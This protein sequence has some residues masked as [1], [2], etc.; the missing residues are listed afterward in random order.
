MDRRNVGAVLL[1]L[2]LLAV[3]AVGGVAATQA[4]GVGTVDAQ[5]DSAVADAD[6]DTA[7]VQPGLREASGETEV[8]VSLPASDSASSPAALRAHASVT[9]EPLM[10]FAADRPGVTV[11]QTFWLANAALVT[12]DTARVS[13]SD[14]AAVAG[15]RALHENAEFETTAGATAGAALP[16]PA[17]G[18]ANNSYTYGLEQINAPTAWES[19]N[20]TGENASV[21][22]LDT[23]VAASHPDLEVAGWQEFDG[24]GNPVDSEPN[25]GDGHGT[26]V[27]GTVSGPMNPA[28]D[29]PAYG[30]APDVDLYGVKVLTDD[31]GGSFAQIIAGME[32]AVNE[33]VDVISMSLGATGFYEQM[34]EPVQNAHAAGTIVVAS[35]GNSGQGSTG[36]P[37]NVYESVAVGASNSNQGIADF[38]SGEVVDTAADWGDSAPADWPD[39]YTV[40]TVAA[41]GVSTLSSVPGGG[42][43]GTYSGTSMAAPHVSGV[44]ALAESAIDR[45]LS[46]QEIEAALEAT[47]FKPADAPA[48]PGE[49]DD[50]YGSGIVDASAFIAFLQDTDGPLLTLTASA[51]TTVETNESLTVNYTV[52]NLGGAAGTESEINLVVNGTVADTETNTTV[53]PNETVTGSLTFDGVDG[54]EEGD[55]IEWTVEMVDTNTTSSGSTSVGL[56]PGTEIAIQSIEYPDV[57]GPNGELSVNYTLENLGAESGTESFVDLIVNG[58]DSGF[59]DTDFD[60]TVPGGGTASGTLTFSSVSDYFGPDET[61]EFTVE[62]WDFGDVAAGNTTVEV[63]DEPVLGLVSADA[64]TT[65]T[66]GDDL[67]INYTIENIGSVAGTESSVELLVNGTPE[68]VDT[69]VSVPGQ[70][71]ANGTLVFENVDASALSRS[72]SVETGGEQSEPADSVQVDRTLREASGE[73]EVM[74]SLPASDRADSPAAL[75]AHASA[76]QEPL[77][78]FAANRPGVTVEQTF[79]LA[80]AALVTVDTARVSL[81][82]LA[83]VE[84]VRALHENT[85]FETTAGATAG[86]ALAQPAVGTA[87]DSYTYGLEQVNAPTAWESYNTTGANAS[88]AVLDT[89]VAASHPDID[90]AGWQEFDSNGNPVDSEPNDGNGHGTHVSG[91]VSGPMNPAGDVPAYGVAPDVDLYG[92]KVLD[93]G[94]SLAQIFAGME[95]AVDQNVDIISMSLGATGFSPSM[96]EPV[97]NAHAAGTVVVASAG[98]S[99]Q[100]SSGSPGNVYDSIAVG[101]S[102]SNQ[103]IADF[104]SGEVVDT[105]SA[106]GSDAPADWPDQYT[107]PTVA[108]PGVN[109][110]SSVPGGGYDGTYSGTS[111][112]APH[113]SG[114]VALAESAID[115]ELSPQEIE[116]AL[117]A[118]ASKPADAPAPPGERDDRY[119]S[120]IVDATALIAFLQGVEGSVPWTVSLADTGDSTSGEVYLEEPDAVADFQIAA[121]ETNAPLAEG[122]TL[123]LNVTVENIGGA[124]GTQ[125]ITAQSQTLGTATTTVE[126]AANETAEH[127]LTMGLGTGPD[128]VGNHTLTVQTANHS[129]EESVEVQMPAT[130]GAETPPT[131]IDGDDYYEDV[132][133]SGEFDIFDVQAFFLVFGDTMM[134]EHGWAFNF[135]GSGEVTIFDVQALFNELADS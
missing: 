89:G 40:P 130:P 26:H 4:T 34:I 125:N 105:E 9:Q 111:M 102:N 47:A 15:V 113:V 28:G 11:E 122:E 52:E 23:G 103:G 119:G 82:D 116:E 35:A 133:G 85:R 22:V 109:T 17:V 126:L 115:R 71:T 49:R 21:A 124:N 59:D 7:T 100:G 95:W 117:E 106:W 56:L 77:L 104:S 76:T 54:Y 127:T 62:L 27:S 53:E 18:T 108:A 93:G 118:T 29:V 55:S 96:I 97:Q 84:G 123:E 32:W 63:P 43:D 58:T 135:D 39:Q 3:L 92:V 45:A 121:V 69:N 86:A 66:A 68:D 50:R 44:V 60:V 81:S 101:A 24:D 99:G 72:I 132:T 110:L 75:R 131:D 61:I 90:L 16:Q 6:S 67:V 107:V 98:N 25:D 88:V 79:W 20:T 33:S 1:C 8:I 83:A 70:G 31:G 2:G 73:T 91:T 48:P 78:D 120:G 134:T 57:I 10:S 19:Y 38:S 37:G 128:V 12:V 41:P 42:Y 13:L 87:N 74:V 114:V 80:N 51:P 64:P 30:V 14:L 36:S 112:A 65:L 5:S 94:G 46:P 129:V